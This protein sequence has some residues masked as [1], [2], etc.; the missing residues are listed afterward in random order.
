ME[1][2]LS[3]NHLIIV[4]PADVRQKLATKIDPMAHTMEWCDNVYIAVAVTFTRLHN[5]PSDADPL[6][7]LVWV[8][9]LSPNQ[10]RLFTIL[11]QN[12]NVIPMAFSNSNQVKMDHAIE[13]GAA[14]A[15]LTENLNSSLFSFSDPTPRS[16]PLTDNAIMNSESSDDTVDNEHQSTE[17]NKPDKKWHST[18]ITLSREELD[19]LLLDEDE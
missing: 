5:R 4:A 16:E 8:D 12:A 9:N 14:R 6:I 13:M 18:D 10:L 15:I 19:S 11:G 7:V 2:D 17:P 1:S 3:Q